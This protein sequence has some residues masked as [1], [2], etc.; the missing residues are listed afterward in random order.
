[1]QS[2]TKRRLGTFCTA[3]GF[4]CAVLALDGGAASAHEGPEPTPTII[5][6]GNFVC[7]DFA[8]TH[9]GGQQW[10]DVKFDTGE[11]HSGTKGGVTLVWNGDNTF[12]FSST[13]GIDA[14]FV[15]SGSQGSH[16]YV[17]APTA[18][19][20]ETFFDDGLTAPQA[21]SHISFCFDTSE[22]TT[23]AAPPPPPPPPPPTTTTTVA[24]TTTTEA[25]TTTMAT[26][27]T[28]PGAV[29]GITVTAPPP[30]PTPP[31]EVGGVQASQGGQALPRT[32]TDSGSLLALSAGLL[33]GGLILV[34]LGDGA[35]VLGIRRH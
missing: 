5:P 26:T 19:S 23:T 25:P 16:L 2:T 33:V 29:A 22:T 7:S 13:I 12:D 11:L 28:Q 32:G 14:V 1:M 21:I 4:A 8:A 34:F 18:Q 35:R 9:G 30:T 20:M 6:G 10:Q 3:L 24:T 15:K 27:T 31:T 17:Y